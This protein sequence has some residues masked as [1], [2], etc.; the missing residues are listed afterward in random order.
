MLAY[1][2]E[3]TAL[4]MKIICLGLLLFHRMCSE[5]CRVG[6]QGVKQPRLSWLQGAEAVVLGLQG[7]LVAHCWKYRT[8]W[9][10][11]SAVKLTR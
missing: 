10:F 5:D 11:L 4:G 2:K 1:Q 7:V 9:V 6:T 8:S 3:L